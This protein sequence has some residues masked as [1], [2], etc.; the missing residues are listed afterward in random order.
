MT[1][2]L[3]DHL[4]TLYAPTIQVA[5]PSLMTALALS[6]AGGCVG[7]F[8]VLRREALLVLALPQV[9]TLGA[10]IGLRLALPTLPTAGAGVL[11]SLGLIAWSRRRE[12]HL[13]VLPALYVAGVSVSIL[14]V[15]G[16]GAH[17]IEVQNLFTGIDVAVTDRESVVVSTLLLGI[18]GACAALWR[19]WLLLAQAPAVAELAGVHPRRW[20]ALFLLF[21]AALVLLATHAIGGVM[22]VAMLFLPA[23]T[24]LPWCRRIPRAIAASVAI[25]IVTLFTGFVL[26]VECDWPLSHSVGGAGVGLFLLSHALSQ[27]VG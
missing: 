19:R 20:N 13:L 10:A 25:A 1:A 26:S 12:S 8:V 9:V 17:L 27:L 4:R 15:A 11:V 16:A 7:V 24:A 6:V 2:A 18:G 5:W 14:L 21:L 23:A 22:I 3:V